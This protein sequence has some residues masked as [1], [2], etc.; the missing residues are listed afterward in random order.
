TIDLGFAHLDLPNG[1]RVGIVDVPGHER[2]IRN[3]L[4]G[5]TGIDL[6]LLVVAADEGVMPQTREHLDILRFL[7]VRA[8]I[9]VLNKVDLVE[10]RAWLDLVREELAAL[11]AGTFLEGAP[12]LEVSAK[13]GQG[14]PALVQAIQAALQT[15]AARDANAPAR[16]P[17]D[18]AFTMPGFGTVVTGTLWSGRIAPG[19]ILVLL[20][21]G[22]E[23]RVRGVQS[24]G[25]PV[26]AGLAGSRVA[27]NLAGV[28]K[29][30][31]ERGHVLATPGVFA[32][33]DRLDVRLRLLPGA[34]PLAHLGR[35]RLY[36]GADEVIGRVLLADR[37]Q[38][39]GGA[40]ADAQIRLERPTVAD[41]GDPVVI[42]RFSPMVTLGGGTVLDAHP[43]L[44]RRGEGAARVKTTP[45]ERVED[46][47]QAAGASG[48][49]FDELMTKAS[50]TRPQVEQAVAALEAAGGVLVIRGRIFHAATARRLADALTRE[51]GAFHQAAP[52]RP[53]IPREEL[54]PK[55]FPGGDD[56]LYAAVL[57]R[58]IDD[59]AL[60]AAGALLRLPGFAPQLSPQDAAARERIAAALRGARFAPPGR[61][62][63][64]RGIEPARF[65]RLFRA[66][67]DDGTVV[68]VGQGVYFH[69][70][71][72]EEIRRI[73][74]DVVAATGQVTVATLRDRL[75]T[76]RKYALAVLEYFDTIKLT[77][78]VGDAR[79]L[80]RR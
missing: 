7:P 65:E 18:R 60:E 41:I 46:A 36:L 31:I 78:R 23:V 19:D 16:L 69:R 21:P 43:P 57:Q 67:L 59:G 61:E 75:Q 53:G 51:V 54:K 28:E 38:L 1:D 44:R 63:L 50:A 12:V 4:A 5:A 20:P 66:L 22:R 14:L 24:H 39:E 45:E 40:E 56:R 73:V 3:M 68:D 74:E 77:R 27:V 10:D 55:V 72:L 49:S 9:V 80:A 76:S 42:R 64:S 79:V 11:T 26:A 15:V 37:R 30:A 52:W 70:D 25:E 48:I 71:T 62:E 33:T 58:L 29:E 35:V 34:P 13:T 32:P 2:L 47:A 17:I 8:G 6:V